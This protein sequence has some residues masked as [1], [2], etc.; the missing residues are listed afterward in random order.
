MRILV[1][2]D[3][4]EWRE[5]TEA[6]LHAEGLGEVR[7]VG[8]A[9]EAFH[10]LHL[11]TLSPNRISPVDLIILDILMP[12]LG[13]I[14]ACAHIRNHPN[15]ADVPIIMMTAA[16]DV[17]GLASAFEAGAT[18]YVSKPFCQVELLA[19]VR[20]AL[21][22]KEELDRRRAREDELVALARHGS[23]DGEAAR[24]FD[25]L[26]GLFVGKFAEAYIDAL[27]AQPDEPISVL[28]MAIDGIDKIEREQGE[29]EADNVLMRF[30]AVMRDATGTLGAVPGIY[31][32][33]VFVIV[34]PNHGSAAAKALA[35]T[36]RSRAGTPGM[37][38][39]ETGGG[40]Q[41]PT[42]SIG[43]ITARGRQ[44][45]AEQLIGNARVALQAAAA[46]G[47]RVVAVDLSCS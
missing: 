36:L 19:R 47:N 35:E 6:A 10:E 22:T 45:N 40:E 39:K 30:A 2:D 33:G 32:D 29:E 18:D 37:R 9:A 43:L 14:E 8:S 5:L 16:N 27:S 15:L 25:P 24:W 38:D 31:L 3:S 41:Q 42:V 34:A 13:G 46:S 28:A 23:N 12:E 7:S 11:D 20:S 4:P 44:S 21:K 26:T 1:V 17:E